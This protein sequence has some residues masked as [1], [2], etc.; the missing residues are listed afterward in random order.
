MSAAVYLADMASEFGDWLD[1]RLEDVEMSQS[2]L[3]KVSGVSEG[4]LSRYRKGQTIPD[5]ATLRKLAPHLRA[6]FEE[7]MV[8]AGHSPG[9]AGKAGRTFI[10]STDNPNVHRLFKVVSAARHAKDDDIAKAEAI[11]RALFGPPKDR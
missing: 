9:D 7:M 2:K 8:L 1:A 11:L 3:A 10:V 5:P 6:K 4:Q